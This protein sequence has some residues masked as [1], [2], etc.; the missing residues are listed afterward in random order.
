MSKTVLRLGRQRPC[1]GELRQ[2]EVKIV[3]VLKKVVL[4]FIVYTNYGGDKMSPGHFLLSKIVHSQSDVFFVV[5][6]FHVTIWPFV[7]I[8]SG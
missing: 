6:T 2:E 1:E 3:Y 8:F 4:Y 5:T 7:T